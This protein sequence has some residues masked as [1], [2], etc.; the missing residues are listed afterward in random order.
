MAPSLAPERTDSET[1]NRVI[2]G[3]KSVLD[4]ETLTTFAEIVANADQTQLT[5]VLADGV[6]LC[7]QTDPEVF[8][9]EKGGSTREAKGVCGECDLRPDC[10]ILSLIRP[11]RYGVWGGLAERDRRKLLARLVAVRKLATEETDA[12]AAAA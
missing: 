11:E 5:N 1:V 9:P 2:S 8:F 10:L 7:A 3:H 6:N 4:V 12:D